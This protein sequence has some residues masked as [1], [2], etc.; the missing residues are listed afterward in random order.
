NARQIIEGSQ[1]AYTE[2]ARLVVTPELALCGYPPEDLLM[3]PAFLTACDAAVQDIAHALAHLPDLHVVLGH[4][5]AGQAGE[6]RTRSV[7]APSLLNAAS[8]L[9]AGQVIASHAKRELPNYQVFDERRYFISGREAGLGPVVI[10]V[11]GWRLGLL[12]CEDAWF[13]EPAA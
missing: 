5:R 3:R 11:G 6:I 9:N 12:I 1:Q 2:G 13:D 4:P 7:S 10:D 8:V